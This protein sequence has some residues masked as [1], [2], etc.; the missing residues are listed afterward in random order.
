MNWRL[1]TAWV[2]VGAATLGAFTAHQKARKR[3]PEQD[4]GPFWSLVFLRLGWLAAAIYLSILAE[5]APAFWRKGAH[6]E[7]DR[8]L[9]AWWAYWYALLLPFLVWAGLILLGLNKAP[10]AHVQRD[11]LAGGIFTSPSRAWVLCCAAPFV[12]PLFWYGPQ[13]LGLRDEGYPAALWGMLAVSVISLVAIAASGPKQAVAARLEPAAPGRPSPALPPWPEAMA[14]RGIELAPLMQWARV[15]ANRPVP[16]G[17]RNFK[18]RL[19]VLGAESVLP[20]VI[21]AIHTLMSPA[22]GAAPHTLLLAPDDCGQA[23]A[24]ALA[25]GELA[26][27]EGQCTLIVTPRADPQLRERLERWIPKPFRDQQAR[28]EVISLR[29]VT[30]L[31]GPA[32]IWITDAATLSNDVMARLSDP[33]AVSRIGLIVWWDVHLYSGVLAANVW[34]ISR[35]LQ[36][37]VAAKGRR[38]VRILALVRDAFHASA[39]VSSFVRRLL[40]YSFATDRE[41]HV[42]RFFARDVFAHF[43]RS[44]SEYFER[45]PNSQIPRR[46]SHRALVAAVASTSAGWPTYLSTAGEIPDSESMEVLE[47]FIASHPSENLLVPSAAE[48]GVR[49][50]EI[51]EAD[52]LALAEMFC[53]GGRATRPELLHHLGVLPPQNPYVRYLLACLSNGSAPNVSRRLIGAEGHPSIYR[54]HLISALTEQEDTLSGLRDTLLWEEAVLHQTLDEIDERGKLSR[55]EA[56]FIDAE[57][58]RVIEHVYSSRLDRND[59]RN[60]LDTVED[61]PRF[62]RVATEPGS[63]PLCVDEKRLCIEA[64]PGRVFIA[65]GTRYRVRDWSA[66]QRGWIECQRDAGHSH[67]WRERIPRLSQ[68]DKQGEETT[69]SG[70]GLLLKQYPARLR[71]TEDIIGYIRREYD[72]LN[73]THQDQKHWIDPL[74]TSFETAALI[75]QF[76]PEPSLS[77]IL[78]LSQALRHMLPA[79]LGVETDAVEVVPLEG[80]FISGQQVFG[81]AV[82]DLYPHGI[83]LVEAI[84][85]DPQW[86]MTTLKCIRDWLTDLKPGSKLKDCSPFNSPL[87]LATTGGG[88]DPSAGLELLER[89]VP[90]RKPLPPKQND[91]GR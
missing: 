69:V 59:G 54:R 5:S 26:M 65:G 82:V 77:S 84:S 7:F 75:L 78:A 17:A 13:H 76:L 46:S 37:I 67:T 42:D 1:I 38:D 66:E 64:Y 41:I 35:R 47:K 8:A 58:R 45:N 50:L 40:P 60:P 44:H 14:A 55:K 73:G 83:G 33:Q 15:E 61:S 81:L 63:T 72:L 22:G 2:L 89:L 80:H 71:Y 53:Q 16:A 28:P 4:A 68:I 24:V 74:T 70:R 32:G 57:G 79:H 29:S 9:V 86:T 34:A 48:A 87:A 43:I 20:Q 62:V 6:L 88:E 23:E 3:N 51:A 10:G 49:I 52:A 18:N 25:A 91:R 56:R 11:W 27:I 36:R 90:A 19:N 39:Q 21:D 30:N 85:D 12:V 31:G